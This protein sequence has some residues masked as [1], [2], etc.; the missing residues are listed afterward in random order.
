[1]NKHELLCDII[2]ILADLKNNKEFQDNISKEYIRG[3]NDSISE[4]R[5]YRRQG[6]WME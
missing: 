3:I 4:I 6:K 2:Q 5:N 1:M